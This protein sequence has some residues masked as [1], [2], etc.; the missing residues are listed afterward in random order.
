M[1][2]TFHDALEYCT[3]HGMPLADGEMFLRKLTEQERK[4]LNGASFWIPLTRHFFIL[5]GRKNYTKY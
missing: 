1:K 4:M 2:N 3:N 5:S